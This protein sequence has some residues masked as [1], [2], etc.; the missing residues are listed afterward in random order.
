M[1][2]QWEN[3]GTDWGKKQEKLGPLDEKAGKGD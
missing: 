1:E 3:R 2:P